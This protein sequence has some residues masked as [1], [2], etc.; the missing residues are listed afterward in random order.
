MFCRKYDIRFLLDED[1]IGD[2]TIFIEPDSANYFEF[3]LDTLL[4]GIKEI[5]PAISRYSIFNIPN[6]SSSQTTFIIES[7]SQ[8]LDNKGVI[9][10]YNEAGFIVDI[11]PVQINQA[12]QELVYH[13]NDKS[14]ASGLYFYNLEI[15]WLNMASGKMVISR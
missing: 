9:K 6:P 8:K 7:N 15:G 10:I 14:L 11:V 12:K 4:T 13:F 3:R 2:S 5:K 1:E